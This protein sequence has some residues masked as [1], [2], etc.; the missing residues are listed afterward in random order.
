MDVMKRRPASVAL[1][2]AA[3]L[4]WPAAGQDASF[5]D[6][7]EILEVQVP[8]NVSTR[9]GAPVRGLT[10]EDFEVYDRGRRQAISGFDVVDL[11]VLRP[12]AVQGPRA[13]D[14]AIPA[15]ARRHLLLLF[16]LTFATPAS[17]TKAR[18]AAHDFVLSELHPTDLAAVAT[19]S[20]DTGPRLL[21]TF[22]PDRAQLARAIDTLGAPRLLGQQGSVDPLRFMIEDPNRPGMSSTFGE[23]ER[24]AGGFAGRV[25]QEVSE[26]LKVIAKQMDKLET[27]YLRGRVS[28]WVAALD[29]MA[30]VL[31]TVEGRK[32]V[33][34]FTEGF[35]GRLMLGRG[36]D[37]MDKEAETDRLNRHF[38]QSWW[39]DTDDVYGN[40]A[41]QS[42]VGGML[43]TF[44]RADC[45]IQAVDISGIGSESA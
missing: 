8:V 45:L 1:L 19:F 10:A 21:V 28:S 35:D 4:A 24:G 39:G 13:L 32:H 33:V 16:D 9:N 5:D 37:P 43:D 7:T 18:Q 11:D 44:R 3:A 6:V 38:G 40:T 17:V 31:G 20:L 25:D 23:S 30:K 41:L 2:L 29:E 12:E 34:F 22:T 36:P 15:A 14:L 26:Y 27:T 42:Q